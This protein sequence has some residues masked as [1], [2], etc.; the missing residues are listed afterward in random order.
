MKIAITIVLIA[1]AVG[2]ALLLDECGEE[3]APN[4]I[5]GIEGQK[6]VGGRC[7]YREYAGECRYFETEEDVVYFTY[8][9]V[10]DGENVGLEHNKVDGDSGLNDIKIGD[11]FDCRLAFITVGTCT[12]CIFLSD[13]FTFGECGSDAWEL[14]RRLNR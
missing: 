13:N 14:F 2:A 7:G 6:I 5:T 12:P 4:N 3:D 11:W 10:V 8:D 1:S 9:G